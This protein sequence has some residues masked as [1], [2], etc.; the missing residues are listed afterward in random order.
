MRTFNELKIIQ[1]TW[2][3]RSAN[4]SVS[5]GNRVIE[6]LEHRD[7]ICPERTPT[8]RTVLSIREARLVFDRIHGDVI[9]A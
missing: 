7:M 2:L 5:V 1:T 6:E 9:A 3:C 8:G 4:V